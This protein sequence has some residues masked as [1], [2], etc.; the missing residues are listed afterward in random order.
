MEHLCNEFFILREQLYFL[1]LVQ[2]IKP[3]EQKRKN[4]CF[5]C[6]QYFSRSLLFVKNHEDQPIC[7]KKNGYVKKD[8]AKTVIDLEQ[9]TIQSRIG[10]NIVDI[11]YHWSH[12]ASK[13]SFI[14][15]LLYPPRNEE[16]DQKNQRELNCNIV[17]MHR[18]FCCKMEEHVQHYH[19]QSNKKRKKKGRNK[20]LHSILRLYK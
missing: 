6:N 4:C 13:E 3:I 7:K 17:H 1:H 9:H 2:R 5:T 15:S 20:F 10:I 8:I 12:N 19:T 11:K 18:S 16:Q 14:E